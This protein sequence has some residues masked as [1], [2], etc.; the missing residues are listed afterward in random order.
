[1]GSSRVGGDLASS[2]GSCDVSKSACPTRNDGGAGNLIFR[3]GPE[4]KYTPYLCALI[5]EALLTV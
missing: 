4:A 1:M 3:G 5:G 2:L